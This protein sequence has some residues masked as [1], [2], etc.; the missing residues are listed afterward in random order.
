MEN[1][2]NELKKV[3]QEMA[4]EE[5]ISFADALDISIKALRFEVQRRKHLDGESS[6][7]SASDL[8]K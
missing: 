8:L 6:C 1:Q 4:D 2:D 7:G 5:G 3:V